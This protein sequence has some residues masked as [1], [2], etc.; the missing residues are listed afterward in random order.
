[1][2]IKEVRRFE[3]RQQGEQLVEAIR[4]AVSGVPADL[5]EDVMQEMF[6]AALDGELDLSN[7]ESAVHFYRK[8]INRLSANRFKF[9]SLDQPIAGTKGL[10]YAERLAG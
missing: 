5:R 9:V 3:A 10:T 2:T 4:R 8:R 7:I 6:L 1:L